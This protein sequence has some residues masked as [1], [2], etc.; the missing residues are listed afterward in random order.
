MKRIIASL[1]F[2]IV[3]V[4]C[5]AQTKRYFCE[6]QRVK[7]DDFLTSSITLEFGRNIPKDFWGCVN[8]VDEKTGKVIDFAT[9]VDAANYM[10]EKGWKFLQAYSSNSG[11]EHIEHWIFCKDAENFEKAKE[12]LTTRDEYKKRKAQ[13]S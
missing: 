8:I 10:A 12:G 9:I 6:V 13:K 11:K 1:L 3:A 5:Y 2:V 7:N 4:G